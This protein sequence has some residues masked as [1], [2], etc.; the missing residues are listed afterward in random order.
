M[1]LS[2]KRLGLATTLL[3]LALSLPAPALAVQG[4]L[5]GPNPVQVTQQEPSLL[6]LLWNAL[7]SIWGKEG[8]QI[9]PFG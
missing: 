5:H 9:D 1:V 6:R 8:S 7:T 4:R 3:L 2:S